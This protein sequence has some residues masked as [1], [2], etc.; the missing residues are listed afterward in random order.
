MT[1]RW[2]ST[3]RSSLLLAAAALGLA[4]CPGRITNPEELIGGSGAPVCSLGVG[5]VESQLFRDRCAT[6]G[7]HDQTSRAGGLDMG[8]P[9]VSARLVGV[10]SSTC[11]SRPLVVAG[12]YNTG[13]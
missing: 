8:S 5:N 10:P 2:L 9:N 4:A 11:Q 1:T 7:C 12:D 13:V 3:V 6:S